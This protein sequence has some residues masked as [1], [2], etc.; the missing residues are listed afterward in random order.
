VEAKKTSIGKGFRDDDAGAVFD[1]SHV[2]FQEAVVKTCAETRGSKKKPR[3]CPIA[4]G[5]GA[6]KLA[7]PGANALTGYSRRIVDKEPLAR[8]CVAKAEPPAL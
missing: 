8:R 1:R 2:Q 7:L 5:E 6:G 4:D 3:P